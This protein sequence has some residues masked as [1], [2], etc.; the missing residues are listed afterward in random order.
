[1][2][3]DNFNCPNGSDHHQK[4]AKFRDEDNVLWFFGNGK[5]FRLWSKAQ[6][7][8][9]VK[10]YPVWNFSNGRAVPIRKIFVSYPLITKIWTWAKSANSDWIQ[11]YVVV[12][13]ENVY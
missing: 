3:M 10:M 5:I 11:I 13:I 2:K 6:C 8:V 7:C 9:F 4:E 1:M 12:K